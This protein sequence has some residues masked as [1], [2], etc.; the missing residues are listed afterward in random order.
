M[1]DEQDRSGQVVAG[2]Y[3]LLQKI[4][5]GGMG[6][7][8]AG[9]HLEVGRKVAIK[10]L[11]P[12]ASSRPAL[13]ERFRREARAAATIDHENIA[14]CIDIGTTDDGLLFYVMEWL[15]GEDLLTVL[16]RERVL[17]WPRVRVIIAQLCRALAAAHACGI[18]HRDLKPSNLFLVRRGDN[19]DFLKLFDFGIAKL[20]TDEHEGEGLTQFGEVIGTTPYMAPEMAA[21]EVIDHRIDV[22]ATG[23]VLVQ[24]LTGHLPFHGK[25]PRQVL[26]AILKGNP[27]RL[28]DLNPL[29]FASPALDA[30]VQRAL[31]RDRDKRYPDMAALHDALLE[32][33]DDACKILYVDPNAIAAPSDIETESIVT[34]G[35]VSASTSPPATA[36]P[37]DPASRPTAAAGSLGADPPALPL[38]RTPT[39]PIGSKGQPT[40]SKPEAAVT[41][42]SR[43]S[44]LIPIIFL[45]VLAAFIAGYIAMFGVP[46]FLR[47]SPPPVT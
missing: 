27:P 33:P 1:A 11:R 23:V 41:T 36:A 39:R 46:E 7:V 21:G 17:P 38:P 13:V 2:R 44:A 31:H 42:P 35:F 6:S 43:R 4:G 45:L 25:S 29:V 40:P 3:R 20:L 34:R 37:V 9:E 19:P 12:E 15:K 14:E 18:A 47:G 28:H 8:Y 32:L 22:Y 5:S 24:L 26:A 30:V 16:R 10:I